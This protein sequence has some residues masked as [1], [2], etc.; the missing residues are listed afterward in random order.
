MWTGFYFGL[1]AGYTWSESGSVDTTAAVA[2]LSGEGAVTASHFATASALGAAGNWPLRNDG[3]IGGGQIGYNLQ[4]GG[5]LVAGVEADIQGVAGASGSAASG[6]VVPVP[7]ESRFTITTALAVTKKL[8]YLGT[9]RGRFGYLITPSL[10]AYATGGLAYGGVSSSASFF[11]SMNRELDFTEPRFGGAGN[12]SD[13]RVGWTAGGGLEWMFL[14]NWS[15][16]VE[17]LYYDLGRVS[18][19]GG[20]LSDR[21]HSGTGIDQALFTN[22][23]QASTRFNGHIARVGVN[24]HFNFGSA[25]TVASY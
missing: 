19:S 3:F 25:P 10:L 13:T 21:F 12:Y 2:Q 7:R 16:K 11:Q 17:Y 6:S 20:L 9:V 23:A 18:Y 4:F 14:P 1:N 22:A 15:A 8:D 24:Y 5:N